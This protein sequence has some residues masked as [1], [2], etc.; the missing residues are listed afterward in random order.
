MGEEERRG[1]FGEESAESVPISSSSEEEYEEEYEEELEEESD[2]VLEG[3]WG[4][5]RKMRC[6]VGAR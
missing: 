2:D 5:G 6:V 3:L 4:R 1:M